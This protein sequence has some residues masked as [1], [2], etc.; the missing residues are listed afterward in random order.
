VIS[1]ALSR[2]ALVKGERR[3]FLVFHGVLWLLF[4]CDFFDN[5]DFLSHILVVRFI[6]VLDLFFFLF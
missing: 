5:L 4:L 2:P 3:F 1:L 6:Q